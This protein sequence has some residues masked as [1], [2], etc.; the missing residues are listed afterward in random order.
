MGR[1]PLVFSLQLLAIDRYHSDRGTDLPSGQ[2]GQDADFAQ[3]QLGRQSQG[4]YADDGIPRSADVGNF[5]A[6]VGRISLF[7]PS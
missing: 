2:I 4:G 7:S 5:T 1:G 3:G 6:W